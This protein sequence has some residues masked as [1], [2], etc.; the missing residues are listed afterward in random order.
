MGKVIIK[1][2]TI[3][4]CHGV[5]EEEKHKPQRFEI[6]AEIT[7]DFYEAAKND[8]I[9][10]TVNYST[11]TKIITAVATNNVFNL[12]E[13][14]ASRCAEELMENFPQA[15]SVLVCVE[16]PQAPVK[17]EF[18]TMAA[19]V[20]LKRT[21]AYLSLG[22]SMGDK[23]AYLD[24]AVKELSAT[25]GITLKKVSSYMESQPYG[26]V[27]KNTFLNA[28]VQIETYLPPRALLK[29][30]H[31]IEEAGE[32]I[33]TLRWDDRTLDIDIIFYGREVIC[34]EGLTIPH[35]DYLN[36]SFV[37]QPLKQIAPDFLCPIS[38]KR[39]SDI[40]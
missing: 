28:C 20:I 35:A 7:A 31:R 25:R 8:D 14:L 33:R 34:E 4:T 15:S 22:S 10:R 11:A 30:I 26:G 29:E 23:K 19:E 5:N 13:T 24:F 32:R 38:G 39:V 2:L 36:R 18:K 9:S 40:K 12:I 1:K 6:S 21:T 16:K 17:A 37:F 27:A 3:K